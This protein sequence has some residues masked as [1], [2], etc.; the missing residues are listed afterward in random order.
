MG[1]EPPQG[2]VEVVLEGKSEPF[3]VELG[4]EAAPAAAAPPEGEAPAGAAT[5][6]WARDLRDR[7]E[8]A[9][10]G[11]QAGRL[12]ALAG[13]ERLRGLSHRQGELR[14]RRR[15]SRRRAQRTGLEA[16]QGHHFVH[17]G[18]GPAVRHQQHARPS[19][20]GEEGRHAR[21]RRAH[22]HADRERQDRGDALVLPGPPER[23]GPGDRQRPRRR[24]CSCRS[25]SSTMSGPS[26]TPS[27][28]PSRWRRS[29]TPRRRLRGAS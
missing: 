10:L 3:R 29:R 7:L 11:R 6:A 5:R 1:L 24:F 20:G 28:K 19:P 9:R 12:V 8:A 14:R 17:H 2:V 18:V 27:A 16:G 15:T 26:S 23:R 13:V 4:A 25:P 21:R 22:R